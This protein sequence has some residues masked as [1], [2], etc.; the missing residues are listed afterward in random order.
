[1]ANPDTHHVQAIHKIRPT[2]YNW[3]IRKR[4]ISEME[5]NQKQGISDIVYVG[6]S[7]MGQ[8]DVRPKSGISQSEAVINMAN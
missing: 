8:S 3:P 1:M 4:S 7:E 5:A 6:H 2:T